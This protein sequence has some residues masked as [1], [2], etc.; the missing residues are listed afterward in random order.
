MK[1]PLTQEQVMI[2]EMVRE[3]ARAEIEPVAQEY[4]MRGEYPEAIIGK[5]GGLGL[6][7]MMVPERYGG[8]E[9]GAV[10]YSLVLQEIAYSCASV[11]VTL[12]V[13]NLTTE[14]LMNFVTE[15]QNERF[16]RP[17]APG[18]YIG[19]F[20]LTEPGAGILA[21][22]DAVRQAHHQAPDHQEHAGRH[23]G[24]SRGRGTSRVERGFAEGRQEKFF[25]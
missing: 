17:L 14:P 25:N 4:N 2:K 23:G 6:F 15:T 24:R 19:A 8:S 10:S 13:T 18:E 11:A 9:A 5:L 12:S 16:L 21:G 20:A 22:E 7:G 1:L 3:F